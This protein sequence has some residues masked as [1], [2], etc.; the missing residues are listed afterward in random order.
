MVNEKDIEQIVVAL[1]KA[2][3][4]R[5]PLLSDTIVQ[6]YGKDP[7]LIL[8]SCLLSLRAQDRVTVHVCRALFAYVKT[9]AQLCAFDQNK[10][11]KILFPLGFYRKKA[12]VLKSVSCLLLERYDGHVPNDYEQLIAIK[13]I[14]S[15]TANLVLGVA[16]DIP[17]ICVD[18]HVHRISNRLGLVKTKNPEQTEAALA[19]IVPKKYWIE[20]NRLLVMWGQNVCRPVSPK[21]KECAI[22]GLCK[23]VGL[24]AKGLLGE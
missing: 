9:A 11:E 16:F 24:K 4:D 5:R 12:Q 21:C 8:I 20:W 14:G 23:R 19:K 10:L 7:F 17:A 22:N 13:G 1:R 3:E 2:I 6:E 15:K 18:I